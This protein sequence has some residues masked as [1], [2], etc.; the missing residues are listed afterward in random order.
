MCPSGL[1]QQ[2]MAL[3]PIILWCEI[4]TWGSTQM[5]LAAKVEKLRPREGWGLAQGHTT[6]WDGILVC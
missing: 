6:V 3:P 4:H 5:K 2:L 1:G